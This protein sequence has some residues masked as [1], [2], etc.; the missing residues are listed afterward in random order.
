[1]QKNASLNNSGI[2]SYEKC[3]NLANSTLNVYL[4]YIKL[5][6]N[7]K[8]FRRFVLE[9]FITVFNFLRAYLVEKAIYGLRL[10]VFGLLNIFP[11]VCQ[12][13]TSIQ[14]VK[15]GNTYT[16]KSFCWHTWGNDILKNVFEFLYI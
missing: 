15:Y 14:C 3:I 4:L 2:Y 13:A 16:C 10:W 7:T 12:Q 11:P 9:N 6:Q 1:M 5:A 8:Q